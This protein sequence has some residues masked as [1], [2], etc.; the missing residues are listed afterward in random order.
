MMALIT[1]CFLA[2]LLQTVHA[3]SA[4]DELAQSLEAEGLPNV[5]QKYEAALQHDPHNEAARTILKRLIAG[6]YGLAREESLRLRQVVRQ[7]T[8]LS[9]EVLV[10]PEEP[11]EPLI[12]SGTVHNAEDRPIVGALI[13]VFHADTKGYYTPVAAMDE[14]NARL[15]GYMKTDSAGR[16]EFRTIRPGGYPQAPI[17]QHIHMLVTAPGYRDHKCQSTCQ[18]V[19]E[20]DPR[21]AQLGERVVL[22]LFF[23][24]CAFCCSIRRVR[25]AFVATHTHARRIDERDRITVVVVLML[26][27]VLLA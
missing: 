22:A 13:Y 20:D 4:Q 23:L 9:T 5:I 1:F 18:L 10:T 21:M 27:N 14:P 11:G 3:Q 17:P 24:P 8:H 16:Y 25:R 15:F 7:Y 19:F 2:L 26:L 12:L 6:N